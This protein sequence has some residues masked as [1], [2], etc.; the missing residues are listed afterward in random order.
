L[1][2]AS[3]RWPPKFTALAAAKQ[4]K[5]INPSSGRLAEHYKCA[6]CNGSFPAKEIQVDHILPVID[7]SMGFITWDDV[8]K[9]MF[10]EKEGYQVVCKP[11]HQT[12]TNAEKRTAI[13]RKKNKNG[14]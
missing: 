2:S 8:I 3:Q 6:T 14:K 13:E 12:K 10:C 4:G 7:P 5:K 1:R 11:C 9:R